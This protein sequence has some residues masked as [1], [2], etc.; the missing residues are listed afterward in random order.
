MSDHR[1]S[2]WASASNVEDLLRSGVR[3]WFYKKGFLHSKTMVMDDQAASIGTANL[4]NRSL[5]INFEVQSF[6]YDEKICEYL[7]ARFAGDLADSEECLLHD[8][9]KRGVTRKALE[10]VGKLWSSQV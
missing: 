10:S 5:D 6:I 8:W 7:A 1:L 2:H 4:D 9:E 3:I